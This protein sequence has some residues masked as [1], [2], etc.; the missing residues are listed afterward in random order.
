MQHKATNQLLIT[1]SAVVLGGLVSAGPVLAQVPDQPIPLMRV[2][3]N[4]MASGYRS[5]EIVRSAVFNERGEKIGTI[6][7]LIIEP[8]QMV[9]YAILSVGGFLGI[10]DHLVVVP[11]AS[12]KFSEDKIMLPGATKDALSSMPEFSYATK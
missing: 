3:V 7:D 9:P 2:D 1:A 12:L 8:N 4:K 5:S 10:G 6:D 11:F